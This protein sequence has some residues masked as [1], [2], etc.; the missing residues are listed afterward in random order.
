VDASTQ[1]LGGVHAITD[2]SCDYPHPGINGSAEELHP[3]ALEAL[4]ACFPVSLEYS[5][6]MITPP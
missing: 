5:L 3:S 4:R 1:S 6:S 2:A